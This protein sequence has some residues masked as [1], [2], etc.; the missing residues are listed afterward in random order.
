[1]SHSEQEPPTSYT[2]ALFQSLTINQLPP[3]TT[4][5]LSRVLFALDSKDI[6]AYCSFMSPVVTI[7]FTNGINLG[8]NMSNIDV[9]REGLTSFWQGFKSIWH[10]ELMILGSERNVVHEA[11]NHYETL[12]GRQVTVGAVAF[13][14]RDSEG[15]IKGMRIYNDQSPVWSA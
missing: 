5:W 9:V 11:L 10:E 4:S 13:I 14:D 8:P 1:M 12:D 15:K 2:D 6:D 3:S 7:I